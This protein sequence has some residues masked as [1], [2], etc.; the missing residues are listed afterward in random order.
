MSCKLVEN[1]RYCL[2]P[3]WSLHFCNCK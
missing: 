2:E 1:E 3:Y